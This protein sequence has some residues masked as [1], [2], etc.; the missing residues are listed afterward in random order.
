MDNLDSNEE[1]DHDVI[2]MEMLEDICRRSKTHPAVHKREAHYEICGR[3]R[4]K[5]LQ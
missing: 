1:S 3:V 4:Q 5:E 2:S